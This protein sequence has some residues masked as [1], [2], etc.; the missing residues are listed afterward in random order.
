MAAFTVSSARVVA[1]R[2]AI[3]SR[4]RVSAPVMNKAVT[5]RSST[6]RPAMFTRPSSTT[7]GRTMFMV[8]AADDLNS[9]LEQAIQEAKECTDDC[10]VEWDAVEELAAA[11]GDSKD[12]PVTTE[13]APLPD[14]TVAAMAAV[15]KALTEAQSNVSKTQDATAAL[16]A[17]KASLVEVKNT[18]PPTDTGRLAKLEAALERALEEAK[19][20]TEDCATDWDVVEEISS[21]VSKAKK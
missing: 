12:S 11:V 19:A 18:S 7:R 10:A 5:L 14:A 13:P 20:C 4:A 8:R 16:V 2:A 9:S 6:F 15:Q 3:N 1:P 17:A 21:A